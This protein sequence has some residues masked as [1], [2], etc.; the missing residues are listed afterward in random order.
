MK[1]HL[2]DHLR[3]LTDDEL[4]A[5]VYDLG[6]LRRH[7]RAI[8]EALPERVD[9][10]YAAKANPDPRLL[11][12]LRDVVD[13]FEVASGGE[14]RYTR[15]EL[16]RARLAFG[17]PGKS[18]PELAQALDLGVERLHVESEHE[19][20]MLGEHAA[21]RPVEVLLRVNLPVGL[22]EV[23]LAM[24]GRPSPF[25]I[26]PTRLDACLRILAAHPGIRL[27]GV[28]AHLASGLDA[29]AQLRVAGQVIA[30]AV[31]WARSRDIRLREVNI[32]GGMSVDYADPGRRFD[33]H[34]F[35]RGLRRILDDHPGLTVRI[36]PGRSVSAYC[37]WY[38]TRVLDVKHSQGEAFAVLA[39]GTHH[40]RTPAAKGHNQPFEVVARDDWPWPWARP[41]VAGE[42]VT[43]AGQL[44]TP[45]DVLARR[46]PVGRLRAGDR[47]AFAMAGAYAWNI[48][49]HDFLMHP[50][51]GFHYL[52]TAFPDSASPDPGN[53]DSARPGVGAPPPAVHAQPSR[54]GRVARRRG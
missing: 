21:S 12:V 20:R 16:P 53:A 5:Y 17:G 15:E 44:C 42:P 23:S 54:G 45:K 43:L 50:A 39:G 26:D 33:W 46:V 22:G 28:H 37:G 52:D 40:L 51:P 29:G 10:F 32:G 4:P 18:A 31:E 1:P 49:H 47:V 36:E 35:G 30:W 24:G 6:E 48:S 11:R 14:L 25:G 2:E 38:V 41:A 3:R 34:G 27:R 8:R 9:V 7:V 13:G 19:L